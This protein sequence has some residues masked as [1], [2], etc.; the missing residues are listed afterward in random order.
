M[1]A[2]LIKLAPDEVLAI[3]RRE[4]QKEQARFAAVAKE[5][6]PAETQQNVFQGPS[7]SRQSSS[8]RAETS[9]HDLSLKKFH[10]EMLDHGMP[11]IRLLLGC[12]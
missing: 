1:I 12:S 3:G 4:L 11:P 8:G 2:E 10:D 9:R 7:D 6:N 5:I